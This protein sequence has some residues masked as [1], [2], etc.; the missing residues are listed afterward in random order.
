MSTRFSRAAAALAVTYV[1]HGAALAAGDEATVEQ[2]RAFGHVI[3]DLLVQRVLLEHG[4]RDVE[5]QSLPGAARVGSWLERR[6]A[7]IERDAGGRRW[8]VVEYQLVN[9]PQALATVR[10]PRW[11]LPLAGGA[12]VLQVAEWPLSV[13]PLTPRNAFAAGALVPVRPDLAPPHVDTR[14][15]ER[16]LAMLG[17]AQVLVLAAWLGWWLW[18]NRSEAARLPFARARRELRAMQPADTVATPA[19][20]ALHRAFDRTAGQVVQTSTLP[21]LFERAPHLL[22]LREAIEAFYAQST[23]RFYGDEEPPSTSLSLQRLCAELCRAERG[24]AP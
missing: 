3:G 11:D 9:A 22:P 17:T 18:R 20:Q 21:H 23:A 19:W 10:L 14:P 5:P 8:L 16:H 12:G 2:P 6:G 4:G 13:A 1:A 15:I 7:G 24:H